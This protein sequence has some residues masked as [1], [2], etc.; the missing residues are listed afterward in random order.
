M[1]DAGAAGDYSVLN[2][3]ESNSEEE[4]HSL[5]D[6]MDLDDEY[7]ITAGRDHDVKVWDAEKEI[8]IQR[9]VGHNGPITGLKFQAVSW[10]EAGPAERTLISASE[11]GTIR[12]WSI[13]K[14]S[15]PIP[16]IFRKVIGD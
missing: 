7:I 13:K 4:E 8:V 2:S 10:R 1:W 3:E 5:I 11:D 16:D 15:P 9:F 12:E 14:D 6:F